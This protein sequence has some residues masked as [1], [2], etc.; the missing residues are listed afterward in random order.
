MEDSFDPCQGAVTISRKVLKRGSHLCAPNYCRR[1]RPRA[2]YPESVETSTSHVASAASSGPG[3]R[4]GKGRLV[5]SGTNAVSSPLRP[6]VCDC[7]KRSSR[8]G[9]IERF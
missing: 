9:R 2:R 6:F 8:S 5:R 4:N 1:Y 3:R 7:P